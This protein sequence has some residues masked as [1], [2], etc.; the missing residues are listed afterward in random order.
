VERQRAD[1]ELERNG[2]QRSK[3]PLPSAA[4]GKAVAAK[5]KSATFEP[6]EV[7]SPRKRGRMASPPVEENKSS[8][9]RRRTPKSFQVPIVRLL[10]LQLQHW[11]CYR[12]ERVFFKSPI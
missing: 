11:R 5:R 10:K 3:F 8:F 2:V 4:R 6:E 7:P 1:R 12:L 9:G